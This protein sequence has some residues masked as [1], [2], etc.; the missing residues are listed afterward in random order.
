MQVIHECRL[1]SCS[2]NILKIVNT[3]NVYR[4]QENAIPW[5]I[6]KTQSCEHKYFAHWIPGMLVIN[7]MQAK[8]VEVILSSTKHSNKSFIYG[9]LHEFLKTGLLTSNGKKWIERRRLLT[10][11][12]HFNILQQFHTTFKEHS[13]QLLEDIKIETQNKN[14]TDIHDMVSKFTLNTISGK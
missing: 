10:P 12:F 4:L 3:F 5:M 9:F 2:S 8:D 7:L 1:I 11:A 13:D 6:K 14:G